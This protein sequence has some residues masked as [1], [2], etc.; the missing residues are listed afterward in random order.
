MTAP[1]EIVGTNGVGGPEKAA[2][3]VDG[4]ALAVLPPEYNGIFHVTIDTADTVF[5]LVNSRPDE[6]FVGNVL[7]ITGDKTINTAT[8]ATVSIYAAASADQA[9]TA[10]NVEVLTVEVPRSGERTIPNMNIRTLQRG[11]YVNCVSSDVNIHINL[12]GYYT[13][14][15]I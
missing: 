7:S 9:L 10:D 2:K 3:V 4:G 13:L 14:E 15:N 12:F 1:V 5:N 8:D 11:A 6:Y